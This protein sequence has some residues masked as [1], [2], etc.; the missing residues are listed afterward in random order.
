MSHIEGNDHIGG[1]EL[2]WAFIRRPGIGLQPQQLLWTMHHRPATILN[3]TFGSRSDKSFIITPDRK[4]NVFSP[5]AFCVFV[6]SIAMFV[7]MVL[8]R[9]TGATHNILCRLIFVGCFRAS[10]MSFT[11]DVTDGVTKQIIDQ[12]FKLPQVVKRHNAECN[13]NTIYH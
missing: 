2:E 12:I 10:Y 8:L 1:D 11:H 3:T 5:S 13:T 7:W 9:R 6:M 4:A